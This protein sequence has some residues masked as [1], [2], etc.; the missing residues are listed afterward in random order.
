MIRNQWTLI[1]GIP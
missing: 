1:I